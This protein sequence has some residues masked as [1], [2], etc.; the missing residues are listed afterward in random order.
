MYSACLVGTHPHSDLVNLII[1]IVKANMD[2]DAKSKL[3]EEELLS[4]MRYVYN[5]SR[6][7]Q[8]TC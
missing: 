8:L 7:V 1:G 4:Q 3:T 5:Y 6:I 2:V